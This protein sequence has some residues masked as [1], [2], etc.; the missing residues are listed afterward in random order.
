MPEK[1]VNDLQSWSIFP[2]FYYVIIHYLIR[3]YLSLG[4]LGE[5]LGA[6]VETTTSW[7]H[8]I[9]SS[10]GWR[11]LQLT[12]LGLSIW[13]SGGHIKI[14]PS[15]TNHT[16]KTSTV[17]TVQNRCTMYPKLSTGTVSRNLRCFS[18]L[19]SKIWPLG[20]SISPK[21]S[22]QSFSFQV[23]MPFFKLSMFSFDMALLCSA[24]F[25]SPSEPQICGCQHCCRVLRLISAYFSYISFVN[26]M[27]P[28]QPLFFASFFV[29]KWAALLAAHLSKTRRGDEDINWTWV[30]TTMFRMAIP[31]TKLYHPNNPWDWYIY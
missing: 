21:I 18:L 25:H 28:V 17:S 19:P 5:I 2:F 3:S 7:S 14:A 11:S 26:Q 22:L 13:K 10:E 1:P 30:G 9:C 27:S 15:C 20:R 24:P 23:A 8:S 31:Y 4:D 12:V 6:P 29:S 16:L